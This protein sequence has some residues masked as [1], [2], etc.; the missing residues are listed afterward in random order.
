NNII[1]D[2]AGKKRREFALP[3]AATTLKTPDVIIREKA[4]GLTLKVT[5]EQ[6]FYVFEE[7]PNPMLYRFYNKNGLIACIDRSSAT[8]LPKEVR[9]GDKEYPAY[10]AKVYDILLRMQH[11]ANI[12]NNR[13]KE[14]ASISS[15]F[16]RSLSSSIEG[17]DKSIKDAVGAALEASR[18]TQQPLACDIIMKA[19]SMANTSLTFMRDEN[20]KKMLNG[21]RA[22]LEA[23]LKTDILEEPVGLIPQKDDE[24]RALLRAK[25]QPRF[26]ARDRALAL[27][28]LKFVNS[29]LDAMVLSEFAPILHRLNKKSSDGI[30][31]ISWYKCVVP[32]RSI[33]AKSKM[34][35]YLVPKLAGVDK[36]LVEAVA[37]ILIT[38]Y[39]RELDTIVNRDERS[40]TVIIKKDDNKWL[41]LTFTVLLR[42]PRPEFSLRTIT[43]YEHHGSVSTSFANNRHELYR[44][45]IRALR[46]SEPEMSAWIDEE[47]SDATGERTSAS[48]TALQTIKEIAKTKEGMRAIIGGITKPEM[49][50]TGF[51][52]VV[53]SKL[54]ETGIADMKNTYKR[55]QQE[56]RKALED[57]GGKFIG[58]SPQD[59][60][61][62][63]IN[64][65]RREDP[66][67]KV[68]VLD[69]GSFD[70]EMGEEEGIKG[71][72]GVRGVDYC[73]VS[74]EPLK[75]LELNEG[76]APFV[77]LI[78]MAMIG[79]G[80]LDSNPALLSF[81]YEA[82]T[83]EKATDEIVNK[84]MGSLSWII[85][86][87]NVVRFKI[88]DL[89]DGHIRNRIFEA[90]A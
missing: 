34:M 16:Q 68:I 61:A 14:I 9:P 4:T 36:D 43:K 49:D 66:N 15:K 60:L 67:I 76:E 82:F 90:A 55:L 5:E 70:K 71:A 45:T 41:Q 8:Q 31:D 30:M 22:V 69:D 20:S 78:A 7:A 81:A 46:L 75:G 38:P 52:V 6:D 2:I 77:N 83:G 24:L 17:M 65:L 64:F 11:I 18:R 10:V 25:S 50:L 29:D 59:N 56:L 40:A 48:G 26:K 79:V 51:T 58:V 13:L 80:R 19:M 23:L 86:L 57:R 35:L 88:S 84:L 47:P 87:Q 28:L 53:N 3:Y 73:V 33:Y 32:G 44:H 1:V 74:I 72:G 42:A 37:A 63:K 85:K 89:E 21:A 39:T 27:E 54:T 12:R 62:D